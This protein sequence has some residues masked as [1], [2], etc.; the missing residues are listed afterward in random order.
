MAD[1]FER[2]LTWEEMSVGRTFE[3][4][5]RTITESDLGSFVALHGFDE[6]LFTDPNAA[7][8]AGYAGR[9]V[10][11]AL[12]FTF[13]EGLI[14]RSGVLHDTG[15]AFV[16]AEIDVRRPVFVGDT[17]RVRIEITDSRPSKKPD[18]GVVTS[19]NAV[20][21]QRDEETLVYSVVRIVRGPA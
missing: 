15:L 4:A 16:H 12:T 6:P 11:G 17:I 20:R 14:I 7:A 18:R 19:R 3:T 13:A 1:R 5:S 2:G 10:P 21:N 9:L 8:A